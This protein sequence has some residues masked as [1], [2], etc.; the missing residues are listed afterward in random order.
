[1]ASSGLSSRRAR[2]QQDI[3]SITSLCS[4]H[5]VL[6]GA[7]YKLLLE[8]NCQC[9]ALVSSCEGMYVYILSPVVVT[10]SN[11]SLAVFL[12]SPTHRYCRH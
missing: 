6:Q 1:M 2:L 3:E 7:Y 9:T 12:N 4:A 8:G 5:P 10:V 11:E